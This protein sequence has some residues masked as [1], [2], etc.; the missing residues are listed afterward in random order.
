MTKL[1]TT[2]ART[3]RSTRGLPQG[4]IPAIIIG[5]YVLVAVIG[6]MFVFYDPVITSVGDRLLP[7]G[8]VSAA[9]EPRPLGTDGV[10]RDML[11]QLIYGARTSLIIGVSVVGI[12]AVVGV[13]LG[14]MAGY[15]SGWADVS[16]SRLIDVLLAFP[17]ILLAI[18]IAGVLDRSMLVVILALSVANWIGF[19]RLS[20]G[21]ALSF[22]ERPWVDAARLVGVPSPLLLLRHI[23][24]FVIGPVAA[25][26]TTE[27][28]L[29]I[30][31][32]AGLSFLGLGLPPSSV[33]WGQ[34][35]AIGRSYLGSAWWVSAFPGIALSGLVISAGLLGDR[36]TARLTGD[37][38]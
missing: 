25:L 22:R 5:L 28:A 23:I 32:E 4:T 21:I 33:S 30:L 17:G 31:S 36:L 12:S 2:P 15:F 18:I 11:G 35:I 37:R 20:R 6:P 14:T 26:A 29:A 16:I 13:L 19:A 7:P 3:R 10:G 38:R 8:S 9:G 27:F 24:P 34:T 1:L